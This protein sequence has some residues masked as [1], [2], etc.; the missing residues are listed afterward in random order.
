MLTIFKK[1]VIIHLLTNNKGDN[2]VIISEMIKNLEKIKSEIGDVEIFVEY[3]DA[4]GSYSGQAK[5][6]IYSTNNNVFI[7]HGEHIT[8]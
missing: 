7:S 2:I 5:A 4:G 3:G 1:L 8:L 6:E